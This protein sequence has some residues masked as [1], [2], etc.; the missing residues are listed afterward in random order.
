MAMDARRRSLGGGL[1]VGRLLPSAQ[2][3]MVGPFIFFDHIGPV[4]IAAGVDRSLDV[5]PHP[6][7]GLSTVTYLFSGALT[8]RASMGSSEAIRPEAGNW[9]T[10]GRGITHSARFERVRAEGGALHGIQE[11]GRA[12]V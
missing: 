10:A 9:M 1:E 5:R 2:Q 4:D 8:H 12:H 3:H 11:I 6:H 7:I